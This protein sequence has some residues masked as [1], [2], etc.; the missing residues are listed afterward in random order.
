M[1]TEL[2]AALAYASAAVGRREGNLLVAHV[3]ETDRAGLLRRREAV[4]EAAMRR[5]RRMVRLRRRGLPLAYV[6]GSAA[7]W[8]MTLAVGPGVLVPR[9]ESEHL[10][11]AVRDSERTAPGRPV[12]ADIGTG[13]GAIAI[14]IAR[15]LALSEV[16]ASDRSRLAVAVARKNVERWAPSVRVLDAGDLLEP[17]VAYG[18][19]ADVVVM[20]PPYVRTRDLGRVAREV[21]AEPRSALDGGVDGLAVVRRLVAALARGEGVRPGARVWLEVGRG[22]APAVR[23][24]LERLGGPTRVVRDLAGIERVVGGRLGA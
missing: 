6:V 2:A 21:R 12:I 16:V 15:E 19:V 23:G 11:E 20:N 22:Q 10:V 13:S 7:F 1:G 18:V 24:L 4:P 14:A 3:L 17:L 9:P 5:L 8:D